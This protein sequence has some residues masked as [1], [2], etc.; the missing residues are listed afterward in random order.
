MERRSERSER[1]ERSNETHTTRP[2]R[3]IWG[4]G[5]WNTVNTVAQIPFLRTPFLSRTRA[6]LAEGA[7]CLGASLPNCSYP[8]FIQPAASLS[9]HSL[10]TRTQLSPEPKNTR[11]RKPLRIRT[12]PAICASH[13][14]RNCGHTQEPQVICASVHRLYGSVRAPRSAQAQH[15]RKTTMRYVHSFAQAG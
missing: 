7:C 10:L 2:A 3:A 1:S 6:N 8:A 4:R 11:A 5:L 12:K 15:P 9:Q 13:P 14:H